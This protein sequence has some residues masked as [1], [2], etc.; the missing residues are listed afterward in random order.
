MLYGS[1]FSYLFLHNY[2]QKRRVLVLFKVVDEKGSP[3]TTFF[4]GWESQEAKSEVMF[5]LISLFYDLFLLLRDLTYSIFRKP[6]LFHYHN[7]IRIYVVFDL[8]CFTWLNQFCSGYIGVIFKFS[9]GWWSGNH[10]HII[11]Y[12]INQLR[13]KGDYSW[14]IEQKNVREWVCLV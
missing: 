14:I 1:Y 6:V 9:F 4:L 10:F 2:E 8:C 5:G 7:M 13:V 3:T 12:G 11:G